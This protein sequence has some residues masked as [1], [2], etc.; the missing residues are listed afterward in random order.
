MKSRAR[1]NVCGRVAKRICPVDNLPICSLCCAEKRNSYRCNADCIYFKKWKDEQESRFHEYYSRYLQSLS[2]GELE[3]LK[4]NFQTQ[5]AFRYILANSLDGSINYTDEDARQFL[6]FLRDF[7]RIRKSGIIYTPPFQ[8]DRVERWL[9]KFMREIENFA[10]TGYRIGDEDLLRC[11]SREE[12]LLKFFKEH[13]ISGNPYI[14]QLLF[15]LM[16]KDQESRKIISP[17]ESRLILP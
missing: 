2:K 1:C 5:R 7:L 17:H 8:S 11:V 9:N 15:S 13:Y 12:S 4:E 6:A 14:G 16:N 3:D 10:K